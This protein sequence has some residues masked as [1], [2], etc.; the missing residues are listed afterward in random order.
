MHGFRT[1]HGLL[2][3]GGLLLG[4]TAAQPLA[5]QSTWGANGVTVWQ[6]PN[7][8]HL[9]EFGAVNSSGQIAGYAYIAGR[10][11]AAIYTPES[12]IAPLGTLGGSDSYAEDI[13]D[14][15]EAVGY[16]AT[17]DG[18]YHAFLSDGSGMHDLGTLGGEFSRAKGIG[19]TGSV[20]GYSITSDGGTRAFVSDGSSM[21]DLGTLGGT[22]SFAYAINHAGQIVGNAYTGGDATYRPFLSDGS[23]MHDLGTLPG[24]DLGTA[25]AI[26][27]A[28]QVVGQSYT[29]GG[30]SSAFLSDGSGMHD[31]GTLGGSQSVADDIDEDG[32]V[33]G[34]AMNAS[35][36]YRAALWENTGSTYQAFSLE[37]L[38]NDGTTN[39]D[40]IFTQAR[41]ISDDGNYVVARGSNAT[42]GFDG[43]VL[44]E[45]NRA[46]GSVTPE[47]VSLVLL[48]TGL[49]GV[50]AAARRRRR[51]V[52]PAF[53]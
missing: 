37:D 15:G 9:V 11:E 19:P 46:P 22:Q 28:G 6:M 47:P 32:Q 52:E 5:A 24:G 3:A 41:G 30:S 31:L 34:A 26:N 39:R 8:F 50:G 7:A 12:G 38:V 51:N 17:S 23:G 36:V 14:A 21:Q 42:L 18:R 49:V 35:D 43:F 13:N 20:V 1:S 40:W 48:G 27:D 25:F 2:L 16:S 29:G 33:V 10:Y 45:Q 44:L 4:L 53:V